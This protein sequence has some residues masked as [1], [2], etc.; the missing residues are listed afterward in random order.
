[1]FTATPK[2]VHE[3]VE[4]IVSQEAQKMYKISGVSKRSFITPYLV[5]AL[6]RGEHS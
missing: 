1:M 2:Y 3:Y 4:N 6:S 5:R